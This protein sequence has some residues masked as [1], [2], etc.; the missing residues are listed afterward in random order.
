MNDL[1]RAIA[2]RGRSSSRRLVE[3]GTFKVICAHLRRARAKRAPH[4]RA[5]ASKCLSAVVLPP[6]Q[7]PRRETSKSNRELITGLAPWTAVV[8]QF[9]RCSRRLRRHELARLRYDADDLHARTLRDI[10]RVHDVVVANSRMSRDL[11]DLVG[12]PCVDRSQSRRAPIASPR[13]D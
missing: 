6:Q 1:G 13:C 8:R 11:N 9:A 7:R 4:L 10:H 2:S 3:E 5:S 12:P